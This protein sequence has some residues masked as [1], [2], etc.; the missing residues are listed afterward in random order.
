MSRLCFT[1]FA[2][3]ACVS[4][5]VAQT[6]PVLAPSPA[7]QECLLA[8]PSATWT[9]I[10]ATAEEAERIARIQALCHTDCNASEDVGRKDPGTAGAIVRK[11][12]AEVEAI[13]GKERFAKWKAY[14]SERPARM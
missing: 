7:S 14:C 8:T 1:L 10:G 9:S 12:E 5:S 2:L 6:D 13:L 4:V 3:A 11:H